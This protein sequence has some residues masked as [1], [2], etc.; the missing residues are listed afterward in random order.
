MDGD[1]AAVGAEFT[2]RGR[3]EERTVEHRSHIVVT[4]L[5]P[6]QR[7]VWR[8]LDTYMSFVPDRDEWRD[9]EIRFE[10]S[11]AGEGTSLRFTHVGLVPTHECFEACSNGWTFFITESLPQ[12][13][14]TGLGQPIQKLEQPA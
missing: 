10:L 8:V 6:A 2:F 11:P 13:V 9:T 3:D 5:V 14:T 7:V 4:E 12:F 1:A